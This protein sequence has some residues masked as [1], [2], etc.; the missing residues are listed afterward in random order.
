MKQREIPMLS[1]AKRPELVSM[2]LIE[3]CKTKLD[4]VLL[5]AQLSRL[6]YESLNALLCSD[7][8]NFTKMLQGRVNLPCN[9]ENELMT[10]CGN[11]A[12]L[13]WT[14]WKNGFEL[15]EIAK[16]AR[17]ADLERQL[18]ELHEAC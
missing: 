15:Q 4:A 2:H 5:C 18:A 17:I 14:A 10:L 6:S 1:E 16:D 9:K 13:Q 8:S 7:K 12:P 11:F 3:G